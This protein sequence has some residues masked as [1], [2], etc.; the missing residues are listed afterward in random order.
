MAAAMMRF[1]GPPYTGQIRSSKSETNQIFPN[2][3]YKNG[4]TRSR[5]F[6]NFFI[7]GL[8]SAISAFDIRISDFS[9]LRSLRALRD[10]F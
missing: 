5:S 9:F 10:K 4:L 7:S 2:S 8:A 3:K 1:I 6:E